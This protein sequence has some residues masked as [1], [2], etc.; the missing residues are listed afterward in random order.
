M[1][2]IFKYCEY[3]QFERIQSTGIGICIAGNIYADSVYQIQ[4][5]QIEVRVDRNM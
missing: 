5:E 1:Q 2:E 4:F 3:I